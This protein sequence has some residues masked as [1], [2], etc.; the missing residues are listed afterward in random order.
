MRSIPH[1]E[2]TAKR[3]MRREYGTRWMKYGAHSFI[4]N[5]GMI[6][7]SKTSAL[8][9]GLK[10]PKSQNAMQ[11]RMPAPANV[12]RSRALSMAHVDAGDPGKGSIT[13]MLGELMKRFLG[14]ASAKAVPDHLTVWI[15]QPHHNTICPDRIRNKVCAIHDSL[16]SLPHHSRLARHLLDQ[17]SYTAVILFFSA[18]SRHQTRTKTPFSLSH[19]A[20]RTT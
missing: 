20:S 8:G 4:R 14:I 19:L 3:I 17:T 1:D 5:E 12:A 16:R 2:I 15:T 7:A 6:S 10:S 18:G 11:T 9:W 13:D